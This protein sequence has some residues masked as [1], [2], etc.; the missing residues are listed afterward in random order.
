MND[1][2]FV[3]AACIPLLVTACQPPPTASRPAEPLLVGG[4]T[5]GMSQPARP[6][7]SPSSEDRLCSDLRTQVVDLANQGE[8]RQAGNPMSKMR[9]LH[10][11]TTYSG[12]PEPSQCNDMREH[13]LGRWQAG[14]GQES[15]AINGVIRN[16]G[17]NMTANSQ[18][19]QCPDFLRYYASA[20]RPYA[21]PMPS[22]MSEIGCL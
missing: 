1:M 21:N 8:L 12:G 22:V 7:P 15:A 2:R 17:C 10:C 4:T 16:L 14:Q 19:R 9:N 5:P 3:V 20:P 13:L 11:R 6:L 18:P